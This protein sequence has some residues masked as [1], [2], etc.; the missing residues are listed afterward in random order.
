MTGKRGRTTRSPGASDLA[1]AASEGIPAG[2]LTCSP[3]SPHTSSNLL[4]LRVFASRCI[5]KRRGQAFLAADPVR[6]NCACEA[7]PSRAG[8]AQRF[9]RF[10]E[11]G[12]G[13]VT[14]IAAKE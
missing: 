8:V 2:E 10:P 5:A 6:R 11:A 12:G 7:R 9:F 13:E 14:S 4:L 3:I 1:L